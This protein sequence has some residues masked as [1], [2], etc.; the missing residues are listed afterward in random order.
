MANRDLLQKASIALFCLVL[1]AACQSSAP[2]QAD[3][4]EDFAIKVGGSPIFN[5]CAST[6]DV[7]N[8]HW[9][10][11]EAPA[12]MPE[13]AGKVIRE[14]ESNCSFTLE[15]TMVVDEVGLWVIQLQVRDANGNTSTDTV[16]VEVVQ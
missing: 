12:T 9:K 15:A 14:T 1:L 6:G 5:G 3:A 11:L 13:D 7:V 2:V 8:Y 10:I 4:G 16:T